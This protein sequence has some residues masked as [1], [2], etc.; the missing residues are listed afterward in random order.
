MCM[1]LQRKSIEMYKLAIL[2]KQHKLV[3]LI[4]KNCFFLT[5]NKQLK[6]LV[7]RGGV[8][9][10]LSVIKLYTTWIQILI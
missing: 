4:M 7:K 9:R 8:Q 3:T 6:Y 10:N 1:I 2:N 5:Q